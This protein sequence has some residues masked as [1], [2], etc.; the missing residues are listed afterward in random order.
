MDD[1]FTD[2]PNYDHIVRYLGPK[3]I[4]NDGSA[5]GSGFRLR[6]DRPDETGLSVHWLEV[7]GDSKQYQ[8]SEVQRLSR[9]TLST[10]GRFA[11]LNVGKLRKKISL[12]L[13]SVRVVHK[14]L[15]AVGDNEADPSHSEITPLPSA[16]S[17]LAKLIG[18]LI[19]DCVEFMHPAKSL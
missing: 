12:E 19:A 17:V 2:L 10:N 9:L 5:D 8:L 13:P 3:K 6:I 11:E 4:R 16:E 7:F 1:S 18:D 15:A 14:P